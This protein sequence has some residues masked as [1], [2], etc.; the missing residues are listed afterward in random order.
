M[1]TNFYL[2][3]NNKKLIQEHFA[4]EKTYGFTDEEYKIVDEPYLGYQ[5]HLNK[6]SA[7]WR[8]LFQRHRTIKTFKDLE[9]LCLDNKNIVGIYD[10]Y[11]KKYTWKQYF[12]RVYDHGQRTPEPRKWVCEK[13]PY[14]KEDDYIVQTTVCSEDEAEI[15]IPFNHKIYDKMEKEAQKKFGIQDRFWLDV[16]YWEDS[17]YPFDWTEGEFF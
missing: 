17:D 11:G 6:L 7:G 16:K 15:Y 3:S 5:V 2:M 1:G 9:K 8:P 10:E 13:N 4:V 14:S 12:D